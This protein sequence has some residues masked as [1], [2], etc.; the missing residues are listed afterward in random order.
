VFT[1]S[2][3]QYVTPVRLTHCWHDSCGSKGRE[4]GK[5]LNS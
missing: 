4:Q 5:L 2:V 1:H 3:R